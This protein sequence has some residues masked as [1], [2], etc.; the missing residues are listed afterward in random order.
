MRLLN[1]GAVRIDLMV[2][3]ICE[4]CPPFGDPGPSLFHIWKET[5]GNVERQ[6]FR[7]EMIVAHRIAS[8]LDVACD[9][10]STIEHVFA[11]LSVKIR[12]HYSLM[13]ERTECKQPGHQTQ[14]YLLAG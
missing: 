11:Q 7:Q 2:G 13:E 12:R 8:V 6:R 5:A 1:G 4:Q 9:V 10:C 14:A 3:R